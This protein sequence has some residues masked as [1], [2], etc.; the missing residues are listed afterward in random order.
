MQT[1]PWNNSLVYVFW[2]PVANQTTP[3][4]K[5][6]DVPLGARCLGRSDVSVCFPLMSFV[7]D[8][9]VSRGA[10]F[11]WESFLPAAGRA[12]HTSPGIDSE[13][14]IIPLRI[15]LLVR[16]RSCGGSR[17]RCRGG[18]GP[19]RRGAPSHGQLA[20]FCQLPGVEEMEMLVRAV[21]TAPSVQPSSPRAL[22]KRSNLLPKQRH[23]RFPGGAVR[24]VHVHTVASRAQIDPWRA[25]VHRWKWAKD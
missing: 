20:P 14:E 9:P 11:Q 22:L 24:P 8:D 13:E 4:S 3:S 2:V 18:T 23:Q 15:P 17:R 25:R 16:V 19:A 21:K 10:V 7:P 12:P 1:T 5:N 6:P